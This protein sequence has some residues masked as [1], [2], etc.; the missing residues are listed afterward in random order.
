MGSP[1]NAPSSAVIV[2]NERVTRARQSSA[3]L[4]LLENAALLVDGGGVSDR[5]RSRV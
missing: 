3:R 2:A 1:L 5:L 4:T